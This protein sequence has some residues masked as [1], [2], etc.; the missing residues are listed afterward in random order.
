[1]FSYATFYRYTAAEDWSAATKLK[2]EENT[3]LGKNGN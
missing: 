3:D 2:K 1:M